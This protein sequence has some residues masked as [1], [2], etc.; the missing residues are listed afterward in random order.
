MVQFVVLT[1][2]LLSLFISKVCAC[3]C[4]ELGALKINSLI[5]IV[6]SPN[7]KCQH[8]I[9][10]PDITMYNIRKKKIGY[11]KKGGKCQLFTFPQPTVEPLQELGK[12]PGPSFIG[13]M[14]P[15]RRLH[16]LSAPAI[17]N[18]A[19]RVNRTSSSL[20]QSWPPKYR[21]DIWAAIKLIRPLHFHRKNTFPWSYLQVCQH[22]FSVSFNYECIC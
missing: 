22:F 7:K 13:G 21:I 2:P 5:L 8:S 1:C 19:Q 10:I 3:E 4:L 14:L 16:R 15:L 9:Y 6:M 17:L 20:P 12:F 18:T 11:E